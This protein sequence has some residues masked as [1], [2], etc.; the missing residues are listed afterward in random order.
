MEH[1]DVNQNENN[2]Q[3]IHSASFEGLCNCLKENHTFLAYQNHQDF[4]IQ[5]YNSDDF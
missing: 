1:Y 3:S 4:F 2:A 5:K